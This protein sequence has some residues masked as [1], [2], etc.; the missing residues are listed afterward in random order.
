MSNARRPHG[1]AT[2]VGL[3][4]SLCVSATH[5]DPLDAVLRVGQV[6]TERAQ[7]SQQRVDQLADTT[8]RHFHD[9]RRVLKELEGLRRYNERLEQQIERQQRRL[10]DL[11]ASIRAAVAVQRQIPG[12]STRMV[13]GLAR[14]IELDQPFHRDERRRRIALLRTSL[15]R[16]DLS[17]AEKFRQILEAYSIEL[18]YGRKIDTYRATVP[19]DGVEREVNVLRIGRVA[20]LYQTTDGER[21]GTWDT[22]ESAWVPLSATAWRGAVTRGLRIARKQAA[23]AL[24][25]LPLAGDGQ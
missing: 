13:E 20:L 19:L 18:E 10:I 21:V 7:S 14:F 9:Y 1:V 4:L 8:Q 23:I 25:K 17:E 16:D 15:G 5:A 12:L 24:M 6:R 11:G 22:R 2:T 3:L